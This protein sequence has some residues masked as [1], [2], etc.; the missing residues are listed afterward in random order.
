M[1]HGEPGI[2]VGVPADEA[3]GGVIATTVLPGKLKAFVAL[4]KVTVG[5]LILCLSIG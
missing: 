2:F 4:G 3:D 5:V 1:P